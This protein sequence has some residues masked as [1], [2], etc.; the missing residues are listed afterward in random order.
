MCVEC[1]MKSNALILILFSILVSACA[2]SNCPREYSETAEVKQNEL[3]QKHELTIC[4][5][6][7][8]PGAKVIQVDEKSKVIGLD[9]WSTTD[10]PSRYDGSCEDN[11]LVRNVRKTPPIALTSDSFGQIKLCYYDASKSNVAL[12]EP[13]QPCPANTTEQTQAVDNCADL[14]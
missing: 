5:G 9:A 12:V 4:K 3:T 13:N 2:N 11:H 6:G 10:R 14:H 7:E 8:R 1:Y